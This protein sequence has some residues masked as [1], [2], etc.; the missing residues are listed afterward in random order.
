MWKPT[1][2][3]FVLNDHT[4][5]KKSRDLFRGL[6]NVCSSPGARGPPVLPWASVSFAQ[7]GCKI[8]R[9]ASIV[10]SSRIL[11]HE[12]RNIER[13]DSDGTW[14]RENVVGRREGVSCWKQCTDATQLH[15]NQPDKRIPTHLVLLMVVKFS[16]NLSRPVYTD[17]QRNNCV[18]SCELQ[19]SFPS[20][21]GSSVSRGSW[22]QPS[23]QKNMKSHQTTG[24]GGS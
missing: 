13:V 6:P 5:E 12:G 14:R 23:S 18:H 22:I 20:S 21:G 2:H 17:H 15:L 11:I 19:M 8:P 7:P 16:W 10:Q 24:S 4:S 3:Q 1:C 9:P